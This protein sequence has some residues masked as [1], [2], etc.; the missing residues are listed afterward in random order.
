MFLLVVYFVD[1]VWVTTVTLRYLAKELTSLLGVHAVGVPVDDNIDVLLDGRLYHGLKT[2]HSLLWMSQIAVPLGNL[3]GQ[4]Q[5][6]ILSLALERLH[7]LL[8]V[9]AW[10]TSVP[11]KVQ[12]V[13]YNGL[14]LLVAQLGPLDLQLPILLDGVDSAR[15]ICTADTPA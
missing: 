4:T 13:Q 7:V 3:H 9:H 2:C 1:D 14:S 5:Q 11:F 12:A 10:P 8:V 15:T 6:R